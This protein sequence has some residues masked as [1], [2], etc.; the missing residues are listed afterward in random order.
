MQRD[1]TK[2]I[3]IIGQP[4][5]NPIQTSETEAIEIE[6]EIDPEDEA[7][8][9]KQAH[10]HRKHEFKA[11]TLESL[12]FTDMESMAWRKHQFR[13]FF[14]NKGHFWTT[15]KNATFWRWVLVITT[16][17]LIG[18]VGCFVSV[19]TEVLTSWKL[20]SCY[21]LLEEGEMGAT[22]FAYQFLS[23]FLVLISG[24]LCC[25][26]PPAAG[27]GI[28]EI[29]A[30]LNG[31]NLSHVV[32]MRVLVAKVVGM[33]FSVASGLPLGKEG[34]MIHVTNYSPTISYIMSSLF[35]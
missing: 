8:D 5:Y 18:L 12:D 21:K 29:K 27:S 35:Y 7:D 15:S 10:A 14:Q 6:H 30:Y 24:A 19:L 32:K 11:E 13:R 2:G 23:M 22:F 26:A 16:G 1:D 3:A 17:I 4:V 33:C 34:P 25:W 31:V 9:H 28:P 20:E